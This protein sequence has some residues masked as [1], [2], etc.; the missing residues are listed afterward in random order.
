MQGRK[1]RCEEVGGGCRTG[2]TDTLSQGKE[3]EKTEIR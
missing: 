1:G 3:E 2:C